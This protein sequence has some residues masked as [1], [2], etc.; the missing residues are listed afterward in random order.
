MFNVDPASPSG[1]SHN[2]KPVGWS[3]GRYWRTRR[4]GKHTMCHVII[5]EVLTG[6]PIPEGMEVDH[7][8]R[9]GFNNAPDNLRLV[10][11]QQNVC[12]TGVRSD[13]GTG[14][15]GV[16]YRAGRKKPYVAHV[17]RHG[18]RKC[19]GFA[20]LMEAEVFVAAMQ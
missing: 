16:S 14:V 7:K 17:Q 10:T 19:K 3:T 20:T 9:N 13:S 8:D 1:L 18:K 12:N 11:R 6:G 15:K 2:G 5:M 4:A